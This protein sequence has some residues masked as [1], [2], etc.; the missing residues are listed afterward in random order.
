MYWAPLENT[1]TVVTYRHVT[2][3]VKSCAS[4]TGYKHPCI[5]APVIDQSHKLKVA[6]SITFR[7]NGKVSMAKTSQS[8]SNTEWLLN[9]H[10]QV[11]L[12]FSKDR[13]SSLK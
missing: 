7:A 2:R 12:W 6:L 5:W 8:G 9:F 3:G 10:F 11:Y 1:R 4:K 13:L